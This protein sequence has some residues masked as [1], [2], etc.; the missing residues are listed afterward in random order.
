MP[1]NS[2]VVTLKM[3]SLPSKEVAER[4]ELADKVSQLRQAGTAF[5]AKV[6]ELESLFQVALNDLREC[7]AREIDQ[8][9]GG[10]E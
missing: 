7:Y 8:I 9:N 4:I 6:R 2:K 1:Q 5:D 10:T 3:P